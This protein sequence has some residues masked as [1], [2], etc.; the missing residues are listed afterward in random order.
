MLGKRAEWEGQQTIY[1][2]NT[3]FFDA[4]KLWSARL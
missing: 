1:I 3:A 2:P 4:D